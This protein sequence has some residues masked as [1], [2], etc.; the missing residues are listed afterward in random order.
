[1]NICIDAFKCLSFFFVEKEFMKYLILYFVNFRKGASRCITVFKHRGEALRD[2]SI[3]DSLVFSAETRAAI[4]QLF[5]LYP[6]TE[7]EASWKFDNV[8]A[9]EG[10]ARKS[11]KSKH[12]AKNAPKFFMGEVDIKNQVEMLASRIQSM[13]FMQQVLDYLP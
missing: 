12:T 11:P 1:M 13:P 5:H 7:N 10:R 6:P 3:L 4:E 9:S 8:P 2:R